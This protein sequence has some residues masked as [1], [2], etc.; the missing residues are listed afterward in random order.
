MADLLQKRQAEHVPLLE[1][2]PANLSTWKF[3]QQVENKMPLTPLTPRSTPVRTIFLN[4][5]LY[6]ATWQLLR[7]SQS[8]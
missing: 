8:S 3:A 7:A 2:D 4:C 6:F 5:V 1:Y